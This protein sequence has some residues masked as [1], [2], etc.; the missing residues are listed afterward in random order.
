MRKMFLPLLMIKEGRERKH[1]LGNRKTVERR[2]M[3]MRREG[4]ES[5]RRQGDA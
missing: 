2:E 1:R 4:R 5:K 3:E